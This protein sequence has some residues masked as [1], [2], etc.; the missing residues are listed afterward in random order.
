MRSLA[1]AE[2]RNICFRVRGSSF[3]LAALHGRSPPAPPAPP[4]HGGPVHGGLQPQLASRHLIAATWLH[5]LPPSLFRLAVTPCGCQPA[6]ELLPAIAPRSNSFVATHR[7]PR[8]SRAV[9]RRGVRALLDHGGGAHP[10]PYAHRHD[11]EALA[12]P[13]ARLR[14]REGGDSP[15]RARRVSAQRRSTQG[16]KRE[17]LRG[18]ARAPAR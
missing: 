10:R 5:A 7:P 18:R 14:G 16:G 15:T 3:A 9:E 2:R 4:A 8:P 11:A 1:P 17:G 6:T 12:G 13:A